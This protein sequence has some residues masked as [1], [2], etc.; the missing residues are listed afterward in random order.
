MNDGWGGTIKRNGCRG[1]MGSGWPG[2]LMRRRERRKFD[3]T[4]W[5]LSPVDLTDKNWEASSHRGAVIV[6]AP[7]EEMAREAAEQAFGVKTRFKP[8]AGV[9]A[10]PWKR[11]SIVKAEQIKD[12]RFELEGATEVLDPS[13]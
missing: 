12:P 4:V 11:D 13:V 9:I 1:T 3:M 6:R 8:G 2:R 7:D 5:K 10:R